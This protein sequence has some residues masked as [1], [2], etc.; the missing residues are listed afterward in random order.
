MSAAGDE[1]PATPADAGNPVEN[2][3]EN[4]RRKETRRAQRTSSSR[5][6]K[7]H[8]TSGSRDGVLGASS[9]STIVVTV[10]YITNLL[11]WK[12]ISVEVI[13]V[14]ASFVS[15]GLI[16]SYHKLRPELDRRLS[17]RDLRRELA[18]DLSEEQR[19]KSEA[20]LRRLERQ[21]LDERLQ[22]LTARSSSTNS[23][24]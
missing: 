12:P 10:N 15:V 8:P 1:S 6:R 9:T 7:S 13:A 14:G 19:S 18:G 22:R 11:G 20:D 2:P 24:G 4:V 21:P 3:P 16:Y 5:A 23:S 17:I